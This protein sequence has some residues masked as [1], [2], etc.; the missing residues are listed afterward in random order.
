MVLIVL[1]NNHNFVINYDHSLPINGLHS[2]FKL[3]LP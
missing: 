1:I 3:L 2:Q